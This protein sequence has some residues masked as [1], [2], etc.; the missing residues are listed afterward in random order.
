MARTELN[1]VRWWLDV[2]ITLCVYV[3]VMPIFQ[4]L[5]RWQ[6]C[7]TIYY[8]QTRRSV[9][10]ILRHL[11]ICLSIKILN[12]TYSIFLLKSHV[13]IRVYF[14][15]INMLL[16]PWKLFEYFCIIIQNYLAFWHV[17][18]VFW[19]KN[20]W[21]VIISYCK[22]DIDFWRSCLNYSTFQFFSCHY[23]TTYT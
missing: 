16:L 15:K 2:F 6:N 3:W 21:V 14:T 23:Y 9:Y 18:G 8:F 13:N 11:C 17:K 22:H 1:S 5:S 4:T 20:N 19:R 7:I 12:S 10:V